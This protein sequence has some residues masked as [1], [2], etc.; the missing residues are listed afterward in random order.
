MESVKLTTLI[1]EEQIRERV[2][3]MGRTLTDRFRGKD[4]IAIAALKGSF[5]FY[6]DLIRE[7]D[8]DIVCEFCAAA[9]Y[10]DGMQSSGE[11]KMTMDIGRS[12]KDR[13]VVLIEDIVD[14]GLTM[15]FL[16]QYFTSRKPKS[17]TTVSLL[18][19]PDALKKSVRIDLVGLQ[20]PEMISWS[21]TGSIIKG[22]SG[23]CRMSPKS[24][25]STN[26]RRP[27]RSNQVSLSRPF[28]SARAQNLFSLA[29][30][31]YP[32]AVDLRCKDCRARAF[33]SSSPNHLSSCDT[34]RSF[35]SLISSPFTSGSS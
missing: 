7:I 31:S 20:D 29:W 18:L 6:A 12:V 4:M 15:N 2:R 34:E 32:H 35:S 11:V 8:T 23:I 33:S 21:A 3:E 26:S 9:S 13:H 10:H 16:R 22:T 1:S 28:P 5:M 19:K 24:R 17:L 14:T 25:I 30:S 27:R